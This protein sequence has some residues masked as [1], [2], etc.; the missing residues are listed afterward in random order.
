MLHCTGWGY[1]DA[2][3]AKSVCFEG[4]PSSGK[5][6][7]IKDLN[8]S[9]FEVSK[10]AP[11]SKWPNLNNSMT[12]GQINEVAEGHIDSLRTE[13]DRKV[14]SDR[15]WMTVFSVKYAISVANGVAFDPSETML[16]IGRMQKHDMNVFLSV[17]VHE[18][19]RRSMM[20]GKRADKQDFQFQSNVLAGYQMIMNNPATIILSGDPPRNQLSIRR[21]IERHLEFTV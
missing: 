12:S 14:I 8:L 16:Q 13:T 7:A 3:W 21:E 9:G 4:L 6:T 17:Q 19:I 2:I 15:G 1:N 20:L 11:H 18:A 5:T 10:R